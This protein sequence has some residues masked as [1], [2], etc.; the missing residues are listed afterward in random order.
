[1]AD[2]ICKWCGDRFHET[3]D[4]YR[5]GVVTTGNMLK[6]KPYYAENGWDSF[7]EQA[8]IQFGDIYCPGCGGLYSDNGRVTVDDEQ[9][10]AESKK[11]VPYSKRKK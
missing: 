4:A 10:A 1:M 11:D 3:T 9:Y 6:L 7:P 5:P 8:H 2:V